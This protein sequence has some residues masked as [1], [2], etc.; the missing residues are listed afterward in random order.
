MLLAAWTLIFFLDTCL[1]PLFDEIELEIVSP[2]EKY[3]FG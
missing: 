3:L 1:L 2:V